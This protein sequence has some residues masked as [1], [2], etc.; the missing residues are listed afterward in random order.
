MASTSGRCSAAVAVP[1][2]LGHSAFS[3]SV[4]PLPGSSRSRQLCCGAFKTQPVESN[5]VRKAFLDIGVS[6]DDWNRASRLEPELLSYGTERVHGILELLLELG[7][8]NRD[9]GTVLIAFPQAFRL[10]LDHHAGPV[11]EFLRTDMG[12]SRE[13]VVA[14]VTRFPSILGMNVKGQLRPQLA[15]LASLGVPPEAVPGLVLARPLV[16]GP[17][18]ESVTT[19]LRRC[20]VP[21]QQMARLLK[22]YPI[23]YRLH[24]RG[25]SAP[26]PS[27]RSP[28][29]WPGGPPSPPP[30][31]G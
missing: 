7:L 2:P 17:G 20:G 14:L 15:F 5:P 27:A 29:W 8:T 18:I 16:L 12:L 25:L 22:S 31:R 6:S 13:Q 11:V 23:D 10:S 30:P 19:F 1:R 28:S 24:I 3:R 26:G 21:R 4:L 9:I